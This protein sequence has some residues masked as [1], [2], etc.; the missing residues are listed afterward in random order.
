MTECRSGAKGISWIFTAVVN[1]NGREK[2]KIAQF[3]H[4]FQTH[5]VIFK[6]SPDFTR[7]TLVDDTCNILWLCRCNMSG[8]TFGFLYLPL[9]PIHI[10]T[11]Y[12]ITLEIDN[13]EWSL[14]KFTRF[15]FRT[16]EPLFAI[17]IGNS[18]F[19]FSNVCHIL[20]C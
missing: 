19:Y 2:R 18:D 10:P 13:Y 12:Y 4:L 7:F 5:F 15:D 14:F 20:S 1:L 6:S 11:R 16:L 9:V 3:C 8:I 17:A